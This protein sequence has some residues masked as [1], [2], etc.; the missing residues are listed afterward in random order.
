MTPILFPEANVSLG[1]PEGLTET[2]VMTI[3]AYV[4]EVVGGSV[5]GVRLV[6]V[7]WRPTAAELEDLNNGG[8]IYLSC[9]GGL[10]PHFLTTK[11]KEAV[12][13]A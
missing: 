11:F 13:P 7:A 10:P 12:K 3:P 9:I 1:A 4:G 2:Q 8:E 6:V 5:D